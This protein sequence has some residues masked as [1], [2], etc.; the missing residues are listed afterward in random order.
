MVDYTQ[1]NKDISGSLVMENY[2]KIQIG[3]TGIIR[4]LIHG[5]YFE[6]L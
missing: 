4:Q 1:L 6:D 3:S 5:N 2:D